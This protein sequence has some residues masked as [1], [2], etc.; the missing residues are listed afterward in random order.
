MN[1]DHLLIE[2]ENFK[3]ILDIPVLGYPNDFVFEDTLFY[4]T[5]YHLNKDG[6]IINTNKI[7]K[8]LHDVIK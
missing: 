8:I 6:R 1:T 3:N 4:D 2:F 5:H 7:I